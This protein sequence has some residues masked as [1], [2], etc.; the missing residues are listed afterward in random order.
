MMATGNNIP[1]FQPVK[2]KTSNNGKV[3][4]NTLKATIKTLLRKNLLLSKW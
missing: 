1:A 4:G 3:N 2:I